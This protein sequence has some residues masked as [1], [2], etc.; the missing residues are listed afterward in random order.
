MFSDAVI[1][2]AAHVAYCSAFASE[3]DERDVA[4]PG[5]ENLCKYVSPLTPAEHDP[6]IRPLLAKIDETLGAP[7]GKIF[8]AGGIVAEEAQIDALSD[9]LLGVQGHGVSITDSYREQWEKGCE[10]CRSQGDLPHD[11]MT[12]YADLA[13]EKLD[14]AGY[15]PEGEEGEDVDPAYEPII[16]TAFSWHGGQESALYAFASTREV[17]SE[18]HRVAVLEEIAGCAKRAEPGDL[19]K[20][21]RLEAAVKAA[22]VGEKF[23]YV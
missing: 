9:L 19:T 20:V 10:A 6:I 8:A 16:A 2:G 14:A 12:E 18:E 11:E 21:Q 4:F 3:A 5:G 15:P 22:K 13:N 7:L 17:Q 1:Y 23:F